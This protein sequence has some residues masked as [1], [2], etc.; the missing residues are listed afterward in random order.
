MAMPFELSSQVA[1]NCGEEEEDRQLVSQWMCDVCRD[2]DTPEFSNPVVM[3]C[4][5]CKAFL[6]RHCRMYPRSVKFLCI[7]R[8]RIRA[9]HVCLVGGPSGRT[10]VATATKAATLAAVMAAAALA[11]VRYGEWWKSYLREFKFFLGL[12]ALP[13]LRWVLLCPA[14]GLRARPWQGDPEPVCAGASV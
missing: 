1:D 2:L 5:V 3:Q 9:V 13:S 10:K 4:V 6:C 11:A 8:H 7:H 12:V 14:M